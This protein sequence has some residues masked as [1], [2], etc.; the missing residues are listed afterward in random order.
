MLFKVKY[1]LLTIMFLFKSIANDE[2]EQLASQM[3]INLHQVTSK[4]TLLG[5]PQNGAYIINLQ[6]NGDGGGTHWTCF[7]IENDHACYFDSYGSPPPDEFE[8][9][10]KRKKK[11]KSKQHLYYLSDQ[12]QHLDSEACGYF[13]LAFLHYM[14]T[15]G[16][17]NFTTRLNQFSALFHYT[18]FKKNEKVLKKYLNKI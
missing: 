13:C 15:H 10:I 1:N 4:D 7:F 6:D 11:P 14:T 3:Q 17:T 5:I 2:L 9:F 12:L 16:Q 18:D 8:D